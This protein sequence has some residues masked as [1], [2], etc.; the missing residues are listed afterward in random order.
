M[1]LNLPYSHPL[2]HLFPKS[3]EQVL[4]CPAEFPATPCVRESLLYGCCHWNTSVLPAVRWPMLLEPSTT[5]TIA[6]NLHDSITRQYHEDPHSLDEETEVQRGKESQVTWLEG[7]RAECHSHTPP[8]PCSSLYSVFL[9]GG[10][11]FIVTFISLPSLHCTAHI[12][13]EQDS[14]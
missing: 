9:C 13:A 10:A 1:S 8:K 6:L 5:H 11:G 7:G 2:S 4:L 14:D 12:G 3:L